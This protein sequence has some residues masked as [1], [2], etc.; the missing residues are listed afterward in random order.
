MSILTQTDSTHIEDICVYIASV[1]HVLSIGIKHTVTC[2]ACVQ[3]R[4]VAVECVLE[5][6][7][8]IALEGTIVQTTFGALVQ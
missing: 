7:G 1:E 3:V 2:L 6:F 4:V 5:V 8:P